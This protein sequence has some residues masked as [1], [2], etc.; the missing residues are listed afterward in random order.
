MSEDLI[1]HVA[2][3]FASHPVSARELCTVVRDQLTPGEPPMLA[4]TAA[5]MAFERRMKEAKSPHCITTVPRHK[6]IW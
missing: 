5:A 4:T 2:H 6:V 1:C 3:D